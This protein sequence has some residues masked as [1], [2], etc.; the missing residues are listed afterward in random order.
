MAKK[1]LRDSMT[2]LLSEHLLPEVGVQGKREANRDLWHTV[3]RA[4]AG[5]AQRTGVYSLFR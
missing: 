4:V 1:Y 2:Q 5:H 3:A